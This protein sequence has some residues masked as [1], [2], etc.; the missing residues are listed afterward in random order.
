MEKWTG[1]DLNP[2]PLPCQ[3]SDLP[4]DLPAREPPVTKGGYEVLREKRPHFSS[5][6]LASDLTGGLLRFAS[7]R[8]NL[9]SHEDAARPERS[10]PPE[11]F[12]PEHAR[13]PEPTPLRDRG[14]SLR[15]DRERLDDASAMGPDRFERGLERELGHAAPAV[16]AVDEEARDSPESLRSF[17]P[18]HLPVA[19]SGVDPWEFVRAAILAPPDRDVAF[20]HEDGMRPAFSDERRFVPAIS[21]LPGLGRPSALDRARSLVVHAPA[22]P[23]L[24]CEFLEIRKGS[25]AQLPRFESHARRLIRPCSSRFTRWSVRGMKVFDGTPVASGE[26]AFV[27]KRRLRFRGEAVYGGK[28]TVARRN[29]PGSSQ[30]SMKQGETKIARPRIR[31]RQM[32]GRPAPGRRRVR[33][34]TTPCPLILD[35]RPRTEWTAPS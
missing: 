6:C 31:P 16:P 17:R 32:F 27:G 5:G 24:A 8:W 20:V 23:L 12:P 15:H 22:T 19:A 4:A 18:P 33:A 11:A 34:P 7:R 14:H 35:Y 13:R 1:W 9:L 25:R 10:D 29:Q 3:D 28:D 2:R 30:D 21:L 26:A